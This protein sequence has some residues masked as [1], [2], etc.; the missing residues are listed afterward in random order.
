MTKCRHKV[1]NK[2]HNTMHIYIAIKFLQ[3]NWL[4][5]LYL[6]HFV[7]IFSKENLSLSD[8]NCWMQINLCIRDESVQSSTTLHIY[9]E[10]IKMKRFITDGGTRIVH[11][12]V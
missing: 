5:L 4:Y 8:T 9:F 1:Q 7:E 10:C 11:H 3:T 12:F 6:K 2:V